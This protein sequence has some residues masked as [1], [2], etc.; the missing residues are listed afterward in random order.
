MDFLNNKWFWIILVVAI[1][2]VIIIYF[3]T[4]KT[5]Y[6]FSSGSEFPAYCDPNKPG[7]DQDGR[8]DPFCG[9]AKP[10]EGSPCTLK[11]GVP[12]TISNGVCTPLYKAECDPYNP[13]FDVNGFP[14]TDCGFG[15]VAGR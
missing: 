6:F 3:A 2:I 14:R 4:N 7:F 15:R 5:G 9:V 10:D 13:G 11:W 8:P 12:G 1:I